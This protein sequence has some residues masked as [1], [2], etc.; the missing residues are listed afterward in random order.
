MEGLR[1][2]IIYPI[3]ASLT[4]GEEL[5]E[6]ERMTNH[7]EDGYETDYGYWDLMEDKIAQ[8]NPR[9]FIPKSKEGKNKKYFSEVV[10][11]SGNVSYAVGKPESVWQKINDYLKENKEE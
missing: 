3:T 4:D 1:I 6:V 10:F 5:T 11:V 8:I 9:C 2:L 7:L